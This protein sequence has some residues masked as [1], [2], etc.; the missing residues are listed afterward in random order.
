[1]SLTGAE[2]AVVI[3]ALVD[4]VHELREGEHHKG[5]RHCNTLRLLLG[6]AEAQLGYAVR[7]ERCGRYEQSVQDY[8]YYNA[9]FKQRTALYRRHLHYVPVGGVYAQRYCGQRVRCQVNKQYVYC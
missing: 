2:D 8:P 9:L 6:R 1:M 3:G 5:H 4:C 7:R